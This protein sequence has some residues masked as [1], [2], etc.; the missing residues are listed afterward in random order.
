MLRISLSDLQP[1]NQ[2]TPQ[3]NSPSWV[4]KVKSALTAK[5]AINYNFSCPAGYVK[6]EAVCLSPGCTG[7]QEPCIAQDQRGNTCSMDSLYASRNAPYQFCPA[8]GASAPEETGVF[9]NP[10]APGGQPIPGTQ[11]M[12]PPGSQPADPGVN[13]VGPEAV[14]PVIVGINW[15]RVGLIAA[16]LALV[17]M[18]VAARKS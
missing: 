10:A 7:A 13:T 14:Q 3:G 1:A 17:G 12:P 9:I 2:A 16:G 5:S 6:H 18:V 11:P 4:A 15:K 8:P